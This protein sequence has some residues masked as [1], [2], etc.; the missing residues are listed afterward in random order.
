MGSR[1][2]LAGAATA[3]LPLLMPGVA[4]GA[5]REEI[6]SFD[7]PVYVTSDPGD[8][9]RLLVAER[10]GIILEDRGG[11]RSVWADLSK[12][13]LCC[14]GE[15]GLLSIVPAPDFHQSDRLYVAYTGEVAAGG[16]AGDIHV[17]SFRHVA[18]G[19]VREPVLAVP[20]S[21]ETD[22]NGGQLQFGPEGALYASFG[23]GGGIGD[24]FNDAQ[25]LESLLG[26]LIRVYPY[27]ESSPPYVVPADN[28]FVHRAAFDEIWGLGLRDPWRFSFDRAGGDLVIADR[29]EN[30]R[31]EIDL[32]PRLVGEPGGRQANYGWDCREGTLTYGGDSSESCKESVDLIDPIFEYPD[33]DHQD[34]TAHGCSI[35]GGYVV[36]DPSVPDL[37]GRYIYGDLCTGVVRSLVLHAP[38]PA[39]TDRA[40]AAL[41]VP[42]ASG[43]ISFGED[44]C[45]RVYIV[46]E[47]GP[48]YRVVGDGP[49]SCEALP[50]R[51]PLEHVARHRTVVAIRAWHGNRDRSIVRLNARVKPCPENRHRR[52][53]LTRDGRRAASRRVRGRCVVGFKVHV[54]D[55]TVFRAL[56]PADHGAKAVRSRRVVVP[57][58]Q[59]R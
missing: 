13:V 27:P 23:D 24:P 26:K 10:R 14:E 6:G 44:A 54:A 37:A 41:S 21:L 22:Q 40:E 42:P 49:R 16:Q 55:R 8:A 28:P 50:P 34:G 47:A 1:A 59:G 9:G 56:L 58:P 38:S 46:T 17:D 39:A 52:L 30:S 12:L 19:L 31:Q 4:A 11:A 2:V 51:T 3:L 18:G 57:G 32:G 45:G 15:R 35:T 7:H 5:A 33:E 29:G 36:R 53:V 48:I 20:H 43:L 25:D